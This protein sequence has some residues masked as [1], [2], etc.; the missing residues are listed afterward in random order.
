M[1]AVLLNQEIGEFRNVEMGRGVECFDRN[2]SC[3]KK[4]SRTAIAVHIDLV[5]RIDLKIGF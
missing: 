5:A 1:K 2:V 4:C 3:R